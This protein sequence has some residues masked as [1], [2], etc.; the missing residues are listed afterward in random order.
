MISPTTLSGVEAPAVMPMRTSPAG[1]Q[2]GGQR[3]LVRADRRDAGC[4][5]RVTQSGLSM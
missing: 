2:P 3:F 5:R 1:S 4:P